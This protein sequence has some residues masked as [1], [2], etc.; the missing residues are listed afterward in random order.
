MGSL[1]NLDMTGPSYNSTGLEVKLTPEFIATGIKFSERFRRGTST[2]H[3]RLRGL[4]L[5][6]TEKG[7][8]W[9]DSY[10]DCQIFD[11]HRQ[12][13]DCWV[14][15]VTLD[16]DWTNKFRVQL[17]YTDGTMSAVMDPSMAAL[18]DKKFSIPLTGQTRAIIIHPPSAEAYDDLVYDD[19]VQ[20]Q[21][22]V[23][24]RRYELVKTWDVVYAADNDDDDD[25]ERRLE[26]LAKYP[27]F[28]E[29][30]DPSEHNL[31]TQGSRFS[32]QPIMVVS[33]DPTP[34]CSLDEDRFSR[35]AEKGNMTVYL[36]YT[37]RYR[38]DGSEEVLTIKGHDQENTGNWPEPGTYHSYIVDSLKSGLTTEREAKAMEKRESVACR[39]VERKARRAWADGVMA[40]KDTNLDEIPT[41]RIA[42]LD[43]TNLINSS[44]HLIEL[45]NNFHDLI[46]KGYRLPT[47]KEF[48]ALTVFFHRFNKKT[49]RITFKDGRRSL[50]FDMNGWRSSNGGVWDSGTEAHFWTKLPKF[51]PPLYSTDRFVIYSGGQGCSGSVSVDGSTGLAMLLIKG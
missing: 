46:P 19:D 33:V 22:L 1:F 10:N 31:L 25:D 41:V 24:G 4:F 47:I 8:N 18:G 12:T 38:L 3:S 27:Q 34:G 36:E 23:P 7:V 35:E 20:F 15:H 51:D 50:T 45:K 16:G 13:A 48:Q 37:V 43:W 32:H 28:M 6:V 9:N 29:S 26:F 21:Y 39:D 49:N 14:N 17:E 42:G 2:Y 30:K 40:M 11:Q 44:G 5:T